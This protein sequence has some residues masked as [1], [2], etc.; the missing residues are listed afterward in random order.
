MYACSSA[1]LTVT[2]ARMVADSEIHCQACLILLSSYVMS[3]NEC[4]IGLHLRT[5]NAISRIHFSETE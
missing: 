4:T 1:V 3:R 5:R 2:V